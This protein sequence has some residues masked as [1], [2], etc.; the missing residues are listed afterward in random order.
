M[1]A[2]HHAHEEGGIPQVPGLCVVAD[3]R[4]GRQRV[5]G[6]LPQVGPGGLDGGPTEAL[7]VLLQQHGCHLQGDRQAA[8]GA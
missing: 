7:L 1:S 8:V 4:V 6:S 3:Q 2:P 5:Q